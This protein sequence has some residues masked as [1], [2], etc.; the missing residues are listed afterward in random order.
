MEVSIK[1]NC[2]IKIPNEFGYFLI[3]LINITEFIVKRMNLRNISIHYIFYSDP[4]CSGIAIMNE[5]WI[6][7][8]TYEI[9]IN[10][11]KI[12]RFNIVKILLHEFTHIKQI[13]DKRLILFKKKT[14]F[15]WLNN[16]YHI[17]NFVNT[18]F[19]DY[20]KLP[21]EKEAIINEKI[22]IHKKYQN[23][24][25]S[26]FLKYLKTNNCFNKQMLL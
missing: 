2:N 26:Q 1:N 7:K 13:R 6:K 25:F 24:E 8:N 21:W 5:H 11:D 14:H 16:K 15:I 23:N 12:E 20:K 4:R 3:Y 19:N 10:V 17:K 22:H 9:F 18:S